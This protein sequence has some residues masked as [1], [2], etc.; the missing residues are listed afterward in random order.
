MKAL[1][2]LHLSEC[3]RKASL[4]WAAYRPREIR[5]VAVPS[6]TRLAL[7]TAST[8]RCMLGGPLPVAAPPQPRASPEQ[9]TSD[10]RSWGGPPV[11]QR[12]H[13]SPCP[14]G[15]ARLRRAQ[16]SGGAWRPHPRLRSDL[17]R[18]LWMAHLWDPGT[19]RLHDGYAVGQ[20]VGEVVWDVRDGPLRWL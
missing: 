9:R 10:T 3:K 20:D 15:H 4:I 5:W 12:K 6:L 17:G 16:C 2:P 14:L 19:V 7:G 8:T 18:E 13:S 11:A 1:K